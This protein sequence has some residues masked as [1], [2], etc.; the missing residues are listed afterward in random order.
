M[1]K[2]IRRYL[3]SPME[4]YLVLKGIFGG[5]WFLTH[6]FTFVSVWQSWSELQIVGQWFPFGGATGFWG[7]L[8]LLS[9]LMHF[10]ALYYNIRVF[11]LAACAFS[12]FFYFAVA[13]CML[14]SNPND[15]SLAEYVIIGLGASYMYMLIM[16]H[17]VPEEGVPFYWSKSRL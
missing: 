8:R 17:I 3:D 16:M 12:A 5:M 9:G 7:G 1:N 6:P 10:V 14:F 15:P 11:R 4:A 2:I 13:I